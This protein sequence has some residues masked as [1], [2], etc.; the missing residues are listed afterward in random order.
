MP[1]C[2]S[3]RPKSASS[4]APARA[5]RSAARAIAAWRRTASSTNCWDSTPWRWA[6]ARVGVG[7]LPLRLL[8]CTAVDGELVPGWLDDRDRPWLRDLLHD[9]DAA[10]GQPLCR[11]ERRWRR[12]EPDP[13]AGRRAAVAQHVLLR[14]L[15]AAA[16]APSRTPVRQALFAAAAERPRDA[17][18]ACVAG[19]LATTPAALLAQLFADLPRE[20]PVPRPEPPLDAGHVLLTA[21]LALAQGLLRRATSAVLWLHG[22]SRAALRTAWLH[23]AHFRVRACDGAATEL[24]W[25][26]PAPGPARG[27]AAI[28]PVLPWVQRYRLQARCRVGEGRGLVVLATGDPIL[29]GPEPRAFDSALERAFARDFAARAPDWQLLREPLP[30]VVGGRLAFPDFELRHRPSGRRWLCELSGL[31]DLAALPAKAALLAAV[32]RLLLCLPRC[33]V[34]PELAAHPR[35][36]LF[37][38]RLDARD[39]L[40]ALAAAP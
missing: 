23:G 5:G 8:S 13:R 36:V 26:P 24:H 14:L 27:L 20:R 4:S 1:A 34:P 15:R 19:A 7:P 29:P 12:G 6:V 10:G 28:V 9:V 39:V 37:D 33:L 31:R 18:L 21:N 35:V 40:G 32:P 11:L 38:R 16:R 22:G 3:T 17:A 30:L 25:E 2:P